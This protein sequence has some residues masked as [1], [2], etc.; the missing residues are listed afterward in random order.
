MNVGQAFL[1]HAKN[2]HF[3]IGREPFYFLR[4]VDVD[5]NAGAL[6]KSGGIPANGG[7]KAEL[8]EQR[9]M[10]QIGESAN[11]VSDT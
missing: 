9:W 1:K 7:G 6:S 4:D 11:F 2:G 3:G 8:I 5:G 10:K